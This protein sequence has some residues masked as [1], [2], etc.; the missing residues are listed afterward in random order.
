[1]TKQ[2][3]FLPLLASYLDLDVSRKLID[4]LGECGKRVRVLK[5]T[6]EF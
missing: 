5:P 3:T 6:E 1:M 2:L 4:E